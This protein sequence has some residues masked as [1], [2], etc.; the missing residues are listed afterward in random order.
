MNFSGSRVCARER[1]RQRGR[2]RLDMHSIQRP[3]YLICTHHTGF[4]ENHEQEVNK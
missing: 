4:D 1:E 2:D 3:E